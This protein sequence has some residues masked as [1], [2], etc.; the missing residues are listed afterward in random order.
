MLLCDLKYRL[1]S[2]SGDEL[3]PEKSIYMDRALPIVNSNL[4][5]SY[6]VERE[7]TREIYTLISQQIL[8][9]AEIALRKI[10]KLT[11]ASKA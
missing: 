4:I 5:A 11:D 9:S 3:I 6:S 7:M 1:L 2:G 8:M 10:D